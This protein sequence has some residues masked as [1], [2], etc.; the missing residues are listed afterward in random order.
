M[1]GSV[2]FST[3]FTERPAVTAGCSQAEVLINVVGVTTSGFSFTGYVAGNK[4]T[5][6]VS[7]G[8]TAVG[9]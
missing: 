6:G 8:W 2:R 3:R 9:I 1:S 7:L 4:S 5:S